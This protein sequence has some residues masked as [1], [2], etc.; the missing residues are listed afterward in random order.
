[1]QRRWKLHRWL[2]AAWFVICG[3][4]LTFAFGQRYGS[5]YRGVSSH[6][7]VTSSV[8]N[9]SMPA[10]E[11][12]STSAYAPVVSSS[13]YSSMVSAPYA[14]MPNRIGGPRRSL[15]DPEDDGSGIGNPAIDPE[16]QG[17]G[18]GIVDDPAPLGSP[19][20]L[21][22]LAGLYVVYRFGKRR[23]ANLIEQKED[24]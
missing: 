9:S 15:G 13:V 5:P 2:L 8:R 14:G 4:M 16:G 10:Y 23:K 6:Y 21:L 3:G 12:H 7:T 19:L 17:N 20:V 22:L 24:F 1:M 11:F 18:I